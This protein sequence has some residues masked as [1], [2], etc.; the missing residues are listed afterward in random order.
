MF[1]TVTLKIPAQ[2]ANIPGKTIIDTKLES[3]HAGISGIT[4]WTPNFE[5]MRKINIQ[6]KIDYTEIFPDGFP[7]ELFSANM[8]RNIE[9]CTLK[10]DF[11]KDS[12]I[13]GAVVNE[14]DKEVDIALILFLRS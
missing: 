6:L 4:I 13:E 14:N 8:F 9:D 3:Q 1:Q 2:T 5:D 12:K 11:P 10:V 7:A